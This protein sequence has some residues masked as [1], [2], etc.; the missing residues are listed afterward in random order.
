MHP[1]GMYMPA[2]WAESCLSSANAFHLSHGSLNKHYSVLV[3][4]GNV[5]SLPRQ[6]A[7]ELFAPFPTNCHS[8]K[9]K[10]VLLTG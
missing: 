9:H 6:E 8:V 4:Y 10:E 2:V 5:F 3:V 7:H 1:I